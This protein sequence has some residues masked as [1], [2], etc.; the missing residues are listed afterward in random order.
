MTR[1]SVV[2][3]EDDHFTRSLLSQTLR[4][5]DLTVLAETAEAAQALELCQTHTPDVAL[6]D[7]DLGPGP[8]GFH[9]AVALRKQQPHIGLVMLTSYLDPRLLHADAPAAPVGSR[10]LRKSD[11]DS[12]VQLVKTILQ[13]KQSPRLA[14]RS[15]QR[16]GPTLT[17]HQLEVLRQVAAGHSTREI[18]E[19]LGVTDK[20][21]EASIS[22]IHKA[23]DPPRSR[24]SATRVKLVQAYYSLTGRTPPRA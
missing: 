8:T 23:F 20:A 2:I 19:S 18:A 5:L 12:P 15:D 16:P 21:V 17:A 22:R 6:L 24:G 7:L 14:Q 1:A 11:L 9:V 3:V 10:F 13:A 4:S